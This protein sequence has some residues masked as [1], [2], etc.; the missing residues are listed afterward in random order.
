MS[1][2]GAIISNARIDGA[3]A[4]DVITDRDWLE[5]TFI[6]TVQQRG[7]AVIKARGASSAASAANGVVDS[8]N[9]IMSA[10]PRDD[11]HSVALISDGSYEV[12]EG[13]ICS[14]PTR[15]DGSK[16]E[17]VQGV[18]LDEFDRAKLA[19]SVAELESELE[20]TRELLPS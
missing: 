3:P 17:I 16:V 15:S 19:L 9:S 7:A 12:P 6:P 20:M 14:F 11:W 5:N 4:T 2:F 1:R 8:V 18:P 10:T 13:L